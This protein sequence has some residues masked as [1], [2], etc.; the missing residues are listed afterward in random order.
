MGDKLTAGEVAKELG[1]HVNHVY[2]LLKQGKLKGQQFNRVWIIDRREVERI[3]A[4]QD[5]HGRLS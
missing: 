4:Q 2:R 1:Y 5:E 3:K